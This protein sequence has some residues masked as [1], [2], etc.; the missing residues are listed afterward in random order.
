MS[1]F[2]LCRSDTTTVAGVFTL[3]NYF[4]SPALHFCHFST[5]PL[6]YSHICSAHKFVAVQSWWLLVPIH[7]SDLRGRLDALAGSLV[8][9]T[10]YWLRRMRRYLLLV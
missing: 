2:A 3:S 5:S 7:C 6:A 4:L 10:T 8:C 1:Y 9:I